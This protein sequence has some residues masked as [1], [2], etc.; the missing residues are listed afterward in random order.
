MKCKILLLSPLP[1]PLGGIASWTLNVLGYLSKT[2]CDVNHLNTAMKFRRVT[3]VSFFARVI[4]GVLDFI[5]LFVKYIKAL[6]LLKPDVIYLT[7]SGSL[8]LLSNYVIVFLAS[9]FR[10]KRILH[11]RFGRVPELAEANNWEFLLLL[12]VINKCDSVIVLDNASYKALCDC[13]GINAKVF[14]VPNP[15]SVRVA[16]FALMKRVASEDYYLF[17]GHVI[18][19]KGIYEL[20]DAYKEI[21]TSAKLLIIGPFEKEFLSELIEFVE[22]YNLCDK[23]IFLGPKS[24]EEVLDYMSRAKA[25]VLPSYTEGFPNVVIEGM[26]CGCPIIATNVGAIEIGRAS[27]GERV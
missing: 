27:C 1:P 9:L 5:Y 15:V 17:V 3:S 16:E 8:G 13:K 11:L 22:K 24:K 19:S 21:K 25:L 6:V 2:R 12:R 7:S 14:K 18:K 20:L 10:I 23:I 26:A 4:T